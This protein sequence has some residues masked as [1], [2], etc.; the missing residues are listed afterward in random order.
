MRRFGKLVAMLVLGLFLF[1]CNAHARAGIS[2]GHASGASASQSS[3]G[4]VPPGHDPNGP[5]NSENAPGRNK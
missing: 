2:T 5:G 1:G 4:K 3:S